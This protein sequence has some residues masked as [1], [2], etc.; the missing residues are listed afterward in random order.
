MRMTGIAKAEAIRLALGLG[1]LGVTV[2]GLST[3]ATG[4]FFN[5]TNHMAPK[6]V[7]GTVSLSTTP[8]SSAFTFANVAPGDVNYGAVTVKNTGTLQSRYALEAT[9]NG[10]ATNLASQL[11]LAG[12]VVPAGGT[13]DAA[14]FSGG[15]VVVAPRT[16][17]TGQLFGNKAVGPQDGDRTLIAGASET[18]CFKVTL[19]S[20]TGNTFQG[21]SAAMTFDFYSEQTANNS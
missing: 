14:G 4:A 12:V 20:E 9:V 13:C 21:K 17:G 2:T 6:I 19:P 10:A 8:A 15:S 7:A 5:S 16:V 1:V 3:V 18:L 11:Q